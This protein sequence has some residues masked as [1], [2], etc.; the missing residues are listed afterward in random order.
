MRNLLM[1]VF[2]FPLSLLGQS[3]LAQHKTIHGIVTSADDGAPLLGAT[4]S[5]KGTS[6]GT[7]TDF[8]GNYTLDVKV[9]DVLIFSYVGFSTQEKT[10][11][12][13][14][15]IINA[16]LIYETSELEEVVVMGY[17][18]TREKAKLTN[19]IATVKVG[20]LEK[21]SFSNPAQALSG[22]VAGLRIS[23][24]SGNPKALPTIVLRGGTSLNL[25]ENNSPLIIVDGQLR[26]DMSDLNLN[27][28]E[29]I[30]VLKD[31]GAT[32]IYGARANNGVILISSKRGYV[33]TSSIRLQFKHGYSFLNQKLDFLNAQ[34]YLT[35]QRRALYESSNVYQTS[36]GA[37]RGWARTTLLT[38]PG[39][40]GTG[41]R[42]FNNDG[43]LINP[44][45]GN[46]TAVAGWSPMLLS[47]P[48]L[49][50]ERIALLKS[51]G[52]QTMTD[53]ITGE[54]MI[55]YEFDRSK[56]AFRSFAL[57][58]DYNLSMAGGNERGKYYVGLGFYE[59]EGLPL[60]NFYKRLN[61][62]FNGE[63]KIKDW[64]KSSSNI[65][66]SYGTWKD[67]INGIND[68]TYFTT[69]FASAPTQKEYVG[70]ILV[71]TRSVG[72]ANPRLYEGVFVRKN[73]TEKLNLGQSFKFD[74]L[75]GLSLTLNANI[76]YDEALYESFNKDHLIAPNTVSRIRQASV[77]YEKTLRQT[78][79]SLLNYDVKIGEHNIQALLGYE[80]F[81][82]YFKNFYAEGQGANTDDFMNL[83]YTSREANMREMNSIHSKSRIKSYF[84]RVNYD[85]QGKYLA[86]LTFRRDGYSSL[87]SN[88]WGNFPGI[89]VGWVFTKENFAQGIDNVLSFGKIRSSYGI[90]GNASKID[91][92]LLQGRYN[93]VIYEGQVGYLLGYIPNIN[94]L[95]ER[96]VTF[97]V[98]A[99]LMFLKNR[100]ST[101]ITY[102]NRLT[103][104][105]HSPI[106]LP[107]SSG[108]SFFTNNNGS[109]RNTGVEIETNFNI[110]NSPNWKWNLALN[111]SYGITKIV[112]LPDNGLERNRQSAIQV[113][114]P[115]TGELIWVSG[116][117]EGQVPHDIYAFEALGIYK[118]EAHVRALAGNLIDES[119]GGSNRKLYG[120]NLWE[121]LTDAEK[122]NALPIRPGD[123]I[124]RDVNGDGKIDDFDRV[125]MGNVVPKWTGGLSTS[126]SYKNIT[127]SSRMDF[128]LGF[129]QVVQGTG[130]I[131]WYLG[132]IDG[133]FNTTEEVKD[134]WTPENPNAKYPR[135]VWRDQNGARNYSRRSSMFVYDGSYLAFRELT[136]SYK[137][138]K[139]ICKTFGATDL[140]LSLTGQN[141]GYLTASKAFSPEMLNIAAS[142]YALPKTVILG[143]N[144]TF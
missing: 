24:D 89:S 144:L 116:L 81:E 110:L 74:L 32:A 92:Y 17:G 127:L 47:N 60:Q 55:F 14:S 43:T 13:K 54:D 23:Q 72:A 132:N 114:E 28:I 140:E 100:I 40:Y 12:E 26:D 65:A 3:L 80:F 121:N 25:N 88:R 52:W 99:D 61:F 83:Q 128:A 95:W 35:W 7:Q 125:R 112:S 34:D 73:E 56:S 15:L 50:P 104:D 85:Y 46:N 109:L 8:D 96:S 143:I 59:Q 70:D 86:S 76:M 134:T 9:G 75:K 82:R 93:S 106:L 42:H 115:N 29:S 27:D 33:G 91:D 126:L 138:E 117:Q 129:K 105:K 71:M 44:N 111:A 63:Y 6:K 122:A 1:C 18:S 66:A 133:S 53:P 124:W 31:A 38:Q 137:I 37:W 45:Y 2:I 58:R 135:F 120:P 113:Y 68:A 22:M 4:V 39:P 19:S 51:Q 49:T 57:T 141:L 78:Y 5:I 69:G 108:S 77:S 36:N 64:L 87:I 10:V 20:N 16:S 107:Y 118:D 130:S 136:L 94:L 67:N 11:D 79:N 30:E 103:K 131:A 98:G 102:Y 21:G 48:T 90:N 97:E 101:G 142:G 84:S 62:T 139:D 123:V 41:N 119:S